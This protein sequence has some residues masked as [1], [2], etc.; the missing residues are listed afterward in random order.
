MMAAELLVGAG[1]IRNTAGMRRAVWVLVFATL[2]ALGACKR[3]KARGDA[4][5]AGPHVAHTVAI[6]PPGYV[7]ATVMDVVPTA[8]GD[9]VL[10]M[11]EGGATVLP[12]FI[13]GT[14]ALTIRLRLEGKH[15]KRPLTHDLLADMMRELGGAPVKVQVDDL[16]DET[17]F[18][19]AFVERNDGTVAELDAR[20]SD[21]IAFALGEK[22]PNFVKQRVFE[23]GGVPTADVH[24][25]GHVT[26]RR[27][28]DPISL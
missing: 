4:G 10:L 14:E 12:I 26:G 23:A 17:Y 1:R 8:S 27:R 20:P 5:A 6:A 16:R 21:C 18:G 3:L 7:R 2:F 13:G 22:V 11:D 25:E 9:A 28:G 24:D 19:S 15:Y